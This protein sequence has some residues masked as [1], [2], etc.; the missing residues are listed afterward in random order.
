MRAA[1]GSRA[2]VVD[3]FEEVED[4]LRSERY[5]RLAR[6]WLPLIG[7]ILA[8]ALIAALAH[9]GWQS[10]ETSR[11][12]KASVTYEQAMEAMGDRNDAATAPEERLR[13]SGRAKAAFTEV[14]RTGNGAY[15][16]LAFQQLGALALEDGDLEDALRFFDEAAK[17]TGDHVVGDPARLK[18]A[19]LVMD[20]GTADDAEKRLEGLAKEHKVTRVFGIKLWGRE[21]SPV[22]VFALEALGLLR[23]Q[24]GKAADARQTFSVLTLLPDAPEGVRQR[25]QV[26]LGVIDAGLAPSVAAVVK[27]QA[28][29]ETAARNPGLVAT[30]PASAAPAPAASAP[31][32][33]E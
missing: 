28:D 4:G 8:L 9:W 2:F 25:A 29:A 11:A 12:A 31:A 20:Q 7:G 32:A 1:S 15:K 16:S 19:Y 22:R 10:Y 17:A 3:I 27:A 18:A 13:A 33:A 23:M 5:R 30:A 14:S 6:T 26:A 21:N 24:T